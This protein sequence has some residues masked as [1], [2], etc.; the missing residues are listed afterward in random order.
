M[1]ITRFYWLVLV[2]FLFVGGISGSSWAGPAPVPKS[3]QTTTYG[4]RDDGALQKGFPLPTPRFRDL[5]N[6]TVKDELT[7]LIWLKDANCFN[8][9]TWAD[10]IA[11]ANALASGA[12]GLS[13]GSVAGDWWLPSIKELESLI[14]SDRI[15]PAL[16]SGHAFTGVQTSSFWSSTTNANSTSRAWNVNLSYGNVNFDNKT[17][18]YYVWPVRGGQ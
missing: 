5:G 9:Q 16:P 3:G 2:G 12:C 6:G 10:A 4:A 1:V 18:S 15:G 13:D 8:P 14:D 17:N 7:G 11:S